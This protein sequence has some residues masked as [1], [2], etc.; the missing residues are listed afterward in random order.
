MDPIAP[1]AVTIADMQD[2][3]QDDVRALI[4]LGLADHWGV[5][6]PDLNPDLN[7]LRQSYAAGRTIVA[8]LNH[9][10]AATGTIIPGAPGVAEIVRISVRKANRR[11]GVGRLIVNELVSTARAWGAS[12][13][14]VET[15][16]NWHAVV[17][18]YRSCGFSVTHNSTSPYGLDTWLTLD[19]QPS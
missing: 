19:L 6:D 16:A 15:S 4:L 17:L 18:F 11:S 3:E 1:S 7:N 13:I 8:R 2:H 5:I 9:G 10:I 12:R 14:D